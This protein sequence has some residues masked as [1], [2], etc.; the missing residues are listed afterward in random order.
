V[1]SARYLRLGSLFVYDHCS[2]HRISRRSA[3]LGVFYLKPLLQAILS[4]SPCKPGGQH[5][6]ATMTKEW[7]KYRETIIDLYERQ[8]LT[9]TE[10]Q[11]RMETEHNFK[12]S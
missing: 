3:F 8:N 4:H 1:C 7:E 10:V 12:A 5:H 9:L 2:W 11:K 6:V